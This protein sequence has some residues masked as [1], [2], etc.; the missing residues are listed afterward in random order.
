MVGL[1]REEAVC[2][3]CEKV[4][5]VLANPTD[6]SSMANHW[7]RF[8]D[9][10][11]STRLKI[12]RARQRENNAKSKIRE[13]DA[14]GRNARCDDCYCEPTVS[15]DFH[16][17]WLAK[18]SGRGSMRNQDNGTGQFTCDHCSENLGRYSLI[19]HLRTKHGV[20]IIGSRRSDTCPICSL[21]LVCSLG[22]HNFK[23]HRVFQTAFCDPCGTEFRYKWGL[24]EHVRNLHL[25]KKTKRPSLFCDLCLKEFPGRHR[26]NLNCHLISKHGLG[27][28]ADR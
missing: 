24:Q 11:D 6:K 20:Q 12:L 21:V 27:S 13:R 17:Y 7:L 16:R 23:H 25:G 19:R 10:S 26:S 8:H 4:L 2:D 28:K 3:A 15:N 1:R 22:E 9:Q 5:V 14:L 18:H